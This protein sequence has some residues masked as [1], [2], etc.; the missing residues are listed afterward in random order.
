MF[1]LD[2]NTTPSRLEMATDSVKNSMFEI[3]KYLQKYTSN[4]NKNITAM[5][6]VCLKTYMQKSTC[7]HWIALL[8]SLF[9]TVTFGKMAIALKAITL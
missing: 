5:I 3:S 8:R 9:F 6:S 1:G 7:I 2:L 4:L